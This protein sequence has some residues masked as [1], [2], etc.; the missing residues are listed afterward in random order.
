MIANDWIWIVDHSVQ[1]GKEK[2][3]AILGIRQSQLPA[4]ETIL[5]HEDVEPLA[6]FPVTK[7]N[8]DVVYVDRAYKFHFFNILII[9]D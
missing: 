5:C 6:L 8:G 4:A 2:C 1:W 7:S 9:S 3:L